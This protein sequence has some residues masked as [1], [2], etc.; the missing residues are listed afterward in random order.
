MTAETR[1]G[2]IQAIRTYATLEAAGA[3][4]IV[5]FGDNESLDHWVLKLMAGRMLL[6]Q[7]YSPS[8][9]QLEK[10][11]ATRG[12]NLRADIFVNRGDAPVWVE[13]RNCPVEKLR[14][15]AQDFHGRI[16]HIDDFWWASVKEIEARAES[17]Y[18]WYLFLGHESTHEPVSF[19]PGIEN[20]HCDLHSTPNWGVAASD[21][22]TLVFLEHGNPKERPIELWSF[23]R[24]SYARACGRNVYEVETIHN[25]EFVPSSRFLHHNWQPDYS[26]QTMHVLSR[27]GR[28]VDDAPQVSGGRG[29]PK[30]GYLVELLLSWGFPAEGVSIRRKTHVGD[31]NFIPYILAEGAGPTIWV[32]RTF[33][34]GEKLRFIRDHFDGRIMVVPDQVEWSIFGDCPSWFTAVAEYWHTYGGILTGWGVARTSDNRLRVFR[35]PDNRWIPWFALDLLMGREIAS[36]WHP[37]VKHYGV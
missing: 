22:G 17:E 28:D 11:T 2:S 30:L 1:N 6:E 9:F 21:D 14:L 35:T 5:P 4:L 36:N 19:I 37:L 10:A 33:M 24:L 34:N 31:R 3:R 16:I 29:A 18:R 27:H 23:L 20:W 32:E 7:G 13:C 25:S 15:I 8:E 26:S 12:Q